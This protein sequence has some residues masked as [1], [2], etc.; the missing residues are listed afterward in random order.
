[1]P[2]LYA[3]VDFSKP[4]VFLDKEIERL[5]MQ[6]VKGARFVDKLVK[7]HLTNGNEQ[8]ILIHIEV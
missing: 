5:G 1:M 7:A 2:Q 3:D 8:W 6:S 4:I